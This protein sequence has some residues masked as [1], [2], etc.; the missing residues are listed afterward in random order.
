MPN[1]DQCKGLCNDKENLFLDINV[2]SIN[3][4]LSLF[5]KKQ[6][7]HATA[8]MHEARASALS[9]KESAWELWAYSKTKIIKNAVGA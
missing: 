9:T 2:L 1:I 6:K 8:L 7:R 4:R 3:S 5:S